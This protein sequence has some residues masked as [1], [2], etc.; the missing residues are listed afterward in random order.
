MNKVR[1]SL[2]SASASLVAILVGLLAGYVIMLISNPVNS[3]AGLL[4]IL[5][6]GWNNGVKGI[7]QV[8]Y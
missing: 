6:G 4:T 2:S 3:F 7:G 5:R 1:K 8:L